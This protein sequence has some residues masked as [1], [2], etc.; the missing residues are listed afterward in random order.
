MVRKGS[1]GGMVRGGS[2]HLARLVPLPEHTVELDHQTGSCVC[3]DVRE[4]AIVYGAH[5]SQFPFDIIHGQLHLSEYLVLAHCV[6]EKQW[7]P[8]CS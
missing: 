2:D 6:C 7:S 5:I 8:L 4:I 3:Q 1:L